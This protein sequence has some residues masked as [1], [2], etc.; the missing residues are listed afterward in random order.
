MGRG[1]LFS[2]LLVAL[3]GQLAAQAI[4]NSATAGVVKIISQK[5]GVEQEGSGFVIGFS[6]DLTFIL[7]AQHVIKDNPDPI[8]EVPS[9]HGDRFQAKVFRVDENH[10][11]AVLRIQGYLAGTISL[12]FDETPVA[13][14]ERVGT[15]GF[16]E[17]ALQPRWAGGS[18]AANEGTHLL[19]DQQLSP[20]H[21]GGPLLR[22]GWVVG[23]VQERQYYNSHALPSAI[24]LPI[25]RNWR[26][27]FKCEDTAELWSRQREELRA[28]RN[29]GDSG[30]QAPPALPSPH[31]GAGRGYPCQGEVTSIAGGSLAVHQLAQR[32]SPVR[33]QLGDRTPVWILESRGSAGEIWYQI[34]T[35][36][37][38][39]G[40]LRQDQLW[41]GSNC[42]Q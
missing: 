23:M 24:I 21:S 1:L 25:L 33:F 41:R 2:L 7:T 28:D 17:G 8:V 22:G 30:F 38:Q 3:A 13:I 39:V 10:D 14:S 15:F 16:P 11:L 31:G 37:G 26:V 4:E 42:P 12:P 6:G 29:E 27:P 9:Q 19:L 5:D 36:A 18:L 40:W 20:G 32:S 34:Q 35:A